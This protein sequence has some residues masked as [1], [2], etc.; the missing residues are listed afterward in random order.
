MSLSQLVYYSPKC[1]EKIRMFVKN[2]PAFIVPNQIGE[3]DLRLAVEL[4]LPLFSAEPD[5]NSGLTVFV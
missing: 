2:R 1:L 5:V 4:N 3:N